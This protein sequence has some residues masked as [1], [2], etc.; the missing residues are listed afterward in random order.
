MSNNGNDAV[1][2]SNEISVRDVIIKIRSGARFLRSKWV[3]ILICSVIGA[4]LGVAY[5]IIK[6]PTYTATCT[7]V[8]EEGEKGGSLSQYSGLAS[9]AGINLGG[10][11]GGIFQGDNLLELYKSRL[12][13]EKTLLSEVKIDGKNQLLIDRYVNFNKLR[14]RWRENDKIDSINFNNDPTNFN[15]MQDSIIIDLV[16]LFNKKILS[17]DK[18]DKKLDIINVSVTTT[19]ELF[20]KEFAN[21]IVASVN[22]F[23][24]QT[25][26][27]NTSQ[28]VQILQKQVDSV[29]AVLNSSISGVASAIDAQPNVNP[30]LLTLRVPSQKKQIDVQSSTAIYGEIVKNLEVSKISLRQET[31][32]IQVIDQPILPLTKTHLGIIK[33]IISGFF[34]AFI[35][36]SLILLIHLMYRALVSNFSETN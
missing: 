17:V 2:N 15:R 4:C 23:Y 31:P 8:L 9:L 28:N 36:T 16:D 21:K 24:V 29:R 34:I 30:A 6:K 11:G 25:K 35:L 14:K 10:S 3:L 20:S 33:G 1:I 12:M 27:K 18:P 26:T 7:F 22:N 13:I 32:L 19:D 5:S